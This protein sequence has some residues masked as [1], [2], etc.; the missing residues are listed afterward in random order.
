MCAWNMLHRESWNEGKSNMN[1]HQSGRN[2]VEIFVDESKSTS[3][4][5]FWLALSKRMPLVVSQNPKGS[6]VALFNVSAP[7]SAILRA[8]WLGSRVVLRV[9]GVYMDRLC[10]NFIG[11]IRPSL[12]RWLIRVLNALPGGREP[13]VELANLIDRNYGIFVRFLLADFIVF[14]SEFSRRCYSRYFFARRPSAVILN[15]STER[16]MGTGPNAPIPI[17]L[18]TVYDGWKPAKRMCDVLR[19]VHWANEVRR[20]PIELL[21]VAAKPD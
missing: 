6:R 14:Q 9:D 3:G 11:Q 16:F 1:P 17:R 21:I 18:A 2:D 7:V 15:G 13:A 20:C 10:D 5:R 12:L 4:Q 8:R 19:F